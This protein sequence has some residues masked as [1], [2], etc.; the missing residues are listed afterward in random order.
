MKK[1]L[2]RHGG[3]SNENLMHFTII[4]DFHDALLNLAEN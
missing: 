1:L 3:K 2:K 4:P